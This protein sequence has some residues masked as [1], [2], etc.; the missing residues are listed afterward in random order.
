MLRIAVVL[1][2]LTGSVSAER[3]I[4]PDGTTKD[5]PEESVPY[6]LKDGYKR[7]ENVMMRDTS[8]EV[9]EVGV[10]SI[11]QMLDRGWWK[12]TESEISDWR[13]ARINANTERILKERDDAEASKRNR[14]ILFIAGV[15]AMLAVVTYLVIRSNRRH[16][17]K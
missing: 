15:V 3:L 13:L 10:D 7:M 1:V 6:A 11:D 2:V 5:V 14:A 4:A 16:A 9:W 8:G 17:G 12:M